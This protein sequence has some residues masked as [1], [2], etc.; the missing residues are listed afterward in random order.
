MVYRP[1]GGQDEASDHGETRSCLHTPSF[2]SERSDAG[3]RH[4][5]TADNGLEREETI[6]LREVVSVD[7][8]G[9]EVVTTVPVV[10]GKFQFLLDDGS[11]VTR[12][13]TTDERGHLVWQGTDLPQAPA[14]QPVYQ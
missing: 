1:G 4:A 7:E 6:Q 2:T 13:Y 11:V 3:A 10:S 9:N 14:P 5:Y 8:D 12:S